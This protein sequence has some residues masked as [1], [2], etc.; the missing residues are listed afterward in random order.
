[1]AQADA[2]FLKSPENRLIRNP[3]PMLFVLIASAQEGLIYLKAG[4]R[5]GYSRCA[6]G[7]EVAACADGLGIF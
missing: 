6:G 5:T 3:K 1:L 2:H 7:L 4:A